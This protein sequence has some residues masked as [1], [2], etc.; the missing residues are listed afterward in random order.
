MKIYFTFIFSILAVV[1]TFSQAILVNETRNDVPNVIS[2]DIVERFETTIQEDYGLVYVDLSLTEL[3]ETKMAGIDNKTAVL[4]DFT[5]RVYSLIDDSKLG[6]KSFKLSGSGKTA[7]KARTSAVR[8]ILRSRRKINDFLAKTMAEVKSTDCTT[9]STMVNNYINTR[10]YKK[11]Y[12]LASSRVEGCEDNMWVV[13][14]KVYDS[15][16]NE[17]C[18]RHI[19]KVNA[20]LSTKNY[21][22]A[23]REIQNVSPTSRC[24]NEVK[25]AIATIKNDFQKDYD[26]SFELYIKSLELQILEE[27]DRRRIMDMLL[28]NNIIN[29]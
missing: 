6:Y 25:S 12:A 16:Q 5:V 26:Q 21:E 1:S 18:E 29:D 8:S 19:T 17:Y 27:K 4:I 20:Y 7:S 11:A 22:K 14:Q 23:I 2:E 28:L 10:Q 15:Y 24:N 9:L 3:N 13:K